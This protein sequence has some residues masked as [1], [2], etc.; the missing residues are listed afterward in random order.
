MRHP[1][2][3]I[4][5]PGI[6]V[7]GASRISRFGNYRP[8]PLLLVL[9]GVFEER[10]VGIK[11]SHF[12]F[13]IVSDENAFVY[14]QEVFVLMSRYNTKNKKSRGHLFVLNSALYTPT[15]SSPLSM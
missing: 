9:G 15:G 14:S 11:V 4:T 2:E 7:A 5:A 12:T 13:T 3:V 10:M 1:A 6:T 8:L